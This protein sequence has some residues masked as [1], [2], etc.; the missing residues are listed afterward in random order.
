MANNQKEQKNESG[1]YGVSIKR[2]SKEKLKKYIQKYL[3]EEYT[4]SY[5]KKFLL[6]QGYDKDLVEKS[7]S[8]LGLK[9]ETELQ[10]KF[11]EIEKK[12]TGASLG[13]GDYKDYLSKMPSWGY[14]AISVVV[15]LAVITM[16]YP[17]EDSDAGNAADDLSRVFTVKDCA[18][19]KNCFLAEAKKCNDAVY[20]QEF[21]GSIIEFS[22]GKLTAEE[23][24]AAGNNNKESNNKENN[25]KN[26]CLITKRFKTFSSQEPK[27]IK[28][29][30]EDLE[31]IC[32]YSKEDFDSTVAN[33]LV[34]GIEKCDGLLKD[35]IYELRIAQIE[36]ELNK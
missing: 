3:D 23:S 16:L 33:D 25:N 26:D 2:I 30:F 34:A 35:A 5:L 12:L 20:E 4:P 18:R 24:A 21:E 14:L 19:D 9:L 1:K 28:D 32:S 10:E 15:L 31:M 36:L 6:E 8:E 7:Y 11:H 29:L 13:L 27:E 17:A 22:S